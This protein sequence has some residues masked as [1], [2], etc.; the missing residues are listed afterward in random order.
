MKVVLF[1]GGLGTRIRDFS[2]AIPKPMIPVG[3]Q[4][5]LCHLMTYYSL[6]GHREFILCLGYKADLIRK[7]FLSHQQQA[8]VYSGEAESNNEVKALRHSEQ[9][10]RVT[11]VDTGLWQNIGERLCAVRKFLAGE[12]I[13]LAN[14]S[15]GLADANLNELIE[16]FKKSN[17]AAAFLAVRPSF[18]LHMV[19]FDQS[20]GVLGLRPTKKADMWVNGGFFIFRQRVFDYIKPGEE[21]VEKPFQRLIEDNALMAFKHESF[22]KPMDTLKDKQVL[23]DMFQ[24]GITPW[25]LDTYPAVAVQGANR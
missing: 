15:D 4:P 18:S 10:W 23:D 24:R 25:R 7:F 5:I 3:D 1:C 12:E 6:Q 19:D 21:L 16:T 9:D 20:G 17:K 8:S 11:L 13:F 22:W 14:Y 2:E